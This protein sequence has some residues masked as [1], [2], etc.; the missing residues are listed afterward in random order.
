MTIISLDTTR[1]TTP[2]S[3]LPIGM[4]LTT[5][6]WYR[7]FTPAAAARSFFPCV[8]PF[9]LYSMRLLAVLLRPFVSV[10]S[11]RAREQTSKIEYRRSPL[12]SGARASRNA[13]QT[14]YFEISCFVGILLYGNMS[15]V[16]RTVLQTKM[17]T[18]PS[19]D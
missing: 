14:P 4:S 2:K 6:L 9:V 7:L 5:L 13:T 18:L 3:V 16:M 17:I 8:F 12:K 15:K 19:L 1:Q 10:R 11:S